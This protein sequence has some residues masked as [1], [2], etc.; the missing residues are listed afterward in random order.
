MM[1]KDKLTKEEKQKLL[2]LFREDFAKYFSVSQIN[3]TYNFNINQ[4]IYFK[5]YDTFAPSFFQNYQIMARDTWPLI[6]YKLYNTIELWWLICRV[7][8]IY[9][10][11]QSPTEGGIIKVLLPEIAKEVMRDIGTR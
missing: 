8:Q 11:T 5:T 1:I 2:K 9:N 6:S 4:N 7:N 10:P 3:G